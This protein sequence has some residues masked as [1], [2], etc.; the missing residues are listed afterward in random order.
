MRGQVLH[1]RAKRHSLQVGGSAMI[2]ISTKN[3]FEVFCWRPA[4]LVEK[5]PL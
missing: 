3:K 1:G 4:D 5:I 2:N